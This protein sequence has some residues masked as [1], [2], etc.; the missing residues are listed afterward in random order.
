M[1]LLKLGIYHPTYLESFYKQRP[2]L[3]NSTYSCQ[4]N[5]LIDDLYGS[6][7][8]WTRPLRRFGYE[9]ADIIANAKPLQVQWAVENH[10]DF[11]DSQWMTSITTT[12]IKQ[13]APDVLL[14]AD[15]S[16]FTAEFLRHLRTEC[17]SIRLI[18]G[19]CGAPWQDERIFK[20]WDAVLTCIPEFVTRFRSL[21]LRSFHVNHA[22]DP[23]I[24]ES[25]A[26]SQVVHDFVFVGSVHKRDQFHIKREELLSYLVRNTDL[27]IWADVPVPADKNYSRFKLVAQKA[28]DLV[29]ASK[30]K[31]ARAAPTPTTEIDPC[32]S[33]RAKPPVFGKDMFRTLRASRVVFN[34]HIDISAKNAS[35]MR[36]FEATGVG[37]CLLTDAKDDLSDLF[38]PD[39]QVVSYRSAEECV[40][41]LRYL[42]EHDDVRRSI[43]AAGQRRTLREHTF[44]RRAETLDKIIRGQ[45]KTG[46]R[47]V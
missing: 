26:S 19:W 13:F 5:A 16:T 23:R 17:R 41:K 14:V 22:F 44:E 29:R 45:L 9:T 39:E 40:E 32:L 38:L 12:Q 6:A 10:V 47:S 34:S 46:V 35:N 37:A 15:Y 31:I 11:D 3:Q 1:R 33:K 30:S 18:L 42:L 24:L 43:A 7:D 21:G 20:E 36:L 8:F 4:H 27:Q 28:V 2:H 25:V